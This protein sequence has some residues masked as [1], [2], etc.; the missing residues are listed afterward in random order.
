MSNYVNADG[1]EG[2]FQS[3]CKLNQNDKVDYIQKM[4]KAV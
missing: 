2:S 1:K 4:C 3:L